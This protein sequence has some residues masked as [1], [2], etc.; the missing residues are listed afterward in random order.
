M[1]Y[2]ATECSNG[3]LVGDRKIRLIRD[4]IWQEWQVRVYKDGTRLDSETYYTDDK[5]D[6]IAT[7]NEM[8][9]EL[10]DKL[11]ENTTLQKQQEANKMDKTALLFWM[12]ILLAYAI[13]GGNDLAM[14]LAGA[15]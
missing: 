4:A 1:Q 11:T 5:E 12:L 2:T 10:T 14:V 15:M 7:M 13:V 6:A 3:I 8:I 9:V